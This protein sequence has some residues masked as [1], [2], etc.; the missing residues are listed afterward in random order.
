MADHWSARAHRFDNAASHIRHPDEWKRVLKA[1]LGEAPRDVVD[2]GAGTGACA[3]IAAELGH[4]VTAVDG[5]E[6]MLACAR[7]SAKQRGLPIRFIQATM[8][9]APLASASADV[10]TMRNVLWTLEH[11]EAA[12][13]LARRLLRPSGIVLIS[14]GLWRKPGE[15]DEAVRTFGAPLPYCNGLTEEDGRRL[16]TEAGFVDITPLHGLF[17][18]NPYDAYGQIPY[19]VLTGSAPL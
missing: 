19:F 17:R 6:G 2:L 9:E 12:L 15:E 8:D 1:A 14:D 10:I 7:E 5:S 11:P 16:L 4:R 18:A 3:L 13:A